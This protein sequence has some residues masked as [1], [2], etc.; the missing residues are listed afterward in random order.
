[1]HRVKTQ[2][3]GIAYMVVARFV[4]ENAAGQSLVIVFSLFNWHEN[5][6]WKNILIRIKIIE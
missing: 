6:E 1:M 2:D 4:C 3:K 5:K